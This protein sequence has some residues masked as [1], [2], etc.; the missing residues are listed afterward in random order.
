MW[1]WRVRKA[2]T[3]LH[4]HQGV[5]RGGVGRS[6][7]MSPRASVS[8]CGVSGAALKWGMPGE[9]QSAT[10]EDGDQERG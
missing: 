4:S 7:E 9:E 3:C 6:R 5:L 1:K 8:G 2:G 10:Q